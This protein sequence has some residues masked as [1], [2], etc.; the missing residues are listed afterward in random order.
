MSE[1]RILQVVTGNF[2]SGGLTQ[3]VYC[4]GQK[5]Y[6]EDVI[7]DYLCRKKYPCGS[8]LTEIHRMGGR[9]SRPKRP[10]NGIRAQ[11]DLARRLRVVQEKAQYDIVHIH[12][13]STYNMLTGILAARRAGF[14]KIILHAHSAGMETHTSRGISLRYLSKI[15]AHRICRAVLP[16]EDAVLCACSEKAADWMYRRRLR[17]KVRI[18]DNGVDPGP[19]QFSRFV[20][21]DV[22]DSHSWNGRF[23]IGHVGRFAYQKN[24]T[25]IL[26]LAKELK[27]TLP[28]ALI[29]LVGEGELFGSICRRASREHLDNIVFEGRSDEVNRLLQAFDLFILPSHF[30]GLPVSAVEAQMA[31]LPCLVSDQ[32]DRACKVL[33]DLQFLP[34]D[35]GTDLWVKE[36][37]KSCKTARSLDP[38][39]KL[40]AGRRR[41]QASRRMMQSDYNVSHTIRQLMDIY[42]SEQA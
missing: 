39:G 14:R 3:I 33:P 42:A 40:E 13:D 34:I 27:Q 36:I 1:Q 26:E 37:V 16:A 38:A 9:V 28:E 22:R 30:E 31:G 23:V 21:K 24:H 10:V 32:I 29:V 7:F 5:L 8:Y 41:A 12:S 19:F 18:I 35:S 2:G 4:W 15:A 25:F 6:A 20:R 11:I 17:R